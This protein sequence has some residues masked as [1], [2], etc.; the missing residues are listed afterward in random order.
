MMD[1]PSEILDY[2]TTYINMENV[3]D[4]I[5][6]LNVFID[7][8]YEDCSLLYM[9]DVTLHKYVDELNNE[10]LTI[11]KKNVDRL[12]MSYSF[13]LTC[14]KYWTILNMQNVCV[15]H[16]INFN[17]MYRIESIKSEQTLS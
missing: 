11:I 5:K 13:G 15:I 6:T 9:P 16:D 7:D 14:F 17:I 2:I 12:K 1:L 4:K 10:K 3:Y 8:E